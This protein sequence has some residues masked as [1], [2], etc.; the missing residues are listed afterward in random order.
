LLPA[1]S[2]NDVT[3]ALRRAGFRP[4]RRAKGSHQAWVRDRPDG[5]KNITIVVLARSRL[6]TSTL[7]DIIAK[8]GLTE[9]E[10]IGLL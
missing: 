5:G 2:S 9:E 1:C 8:A 4:A 10:F 6:A 7:R 3:R